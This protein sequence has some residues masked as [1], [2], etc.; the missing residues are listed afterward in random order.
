[1]SESLNTESYRICS[2]SVM[3]NIADQKI[4]FDENGICN[5]WYETEKKMKS[6]QY[7]EEQCQR[8]VEKLV[9]NIKALRPPGSEYDCLIGV[10]GGVDSSYL[11]Y[12]VHEWGLKP[13]VVHFDNGWN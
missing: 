2:R 5:Y 8:N 4:S 13:L 12:L 10:S 6:I 1:M 9:K 7:T 11:A 3:D